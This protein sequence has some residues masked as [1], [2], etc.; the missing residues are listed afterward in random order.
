SN[1]ALTSG[2]RIEVRVVSLPGV[3]Q[4][5]T[6]HKLPRATNPFLAMRPPNRSRARPPIF[7]ALDSL[8]QRRYRLGDRQRGGQAG[9]LDAEQVHQARDVMLRGP[10]N[11]EIVGRGSR[12]TELRPH[13]DIP[14]RQSAIGSPG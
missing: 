3:A 14:R 5:K 6:T 1:S 13:A 9:R 4:A 11:N 10:L 8:Q 7:Y 12:R 2:R